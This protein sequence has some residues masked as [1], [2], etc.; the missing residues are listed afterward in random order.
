MSKKVWKYCQECG[1]ECLEFESGNVVCPSCK[2]RLSSNQ[3]D[4][5]KKRRKPKRTPFKPLPKEWS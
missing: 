1:S 3:Y 5:D 4:V 2:I